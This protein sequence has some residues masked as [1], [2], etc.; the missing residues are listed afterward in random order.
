MKGDVYFHARFP[1]SDGTFGEKRFVIINAPVKKEPFLVLKTTSRNIPDEL[2]AGCHHERRVFY[3]K[4]GTCNCFPIPTLVQLAE[5][6]ELSQVELVKGHL[7]EKTVEHKGAIPDLIMS[8]L[9]NCLK[10]L[11]EDIAEI[12]AS[13]IFR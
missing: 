4:A 13:M 7:Q 1:Y 5:I 9:I 2:G 8:Q 10:R 11:K 6:F 12:H 3:I